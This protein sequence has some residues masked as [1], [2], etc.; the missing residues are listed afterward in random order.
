MFLTCSQDTDVNNITELQADPLPRYLNTAWDQ[1]CMGVPVDAGQAVSGAV[2]NVRTSKTA[3][4]HIFANIVIGHSSVYPTSRNNFDKTHSYRQDLPHFKS[5]REILLS[6]FLCSIIGGSSSCLLPSPA[7]HIL[8][9]PCPRNSIK[10]YIIYIT[11]VSLSNAILNDN[12]D[13]P[14]VVHSTRTTAL[15]ISPRGKS[16]WSESRLAVGCGHPTPAANLPK[17][18]RTPPDI[19]ERLQS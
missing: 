9:D 11:P 10:T 15:H 12:N 14:P 8:W 4:K 13:L 18:S 19:A 16:P 17:D 5:Q 3:D 2:E 7:L 6:D 1:P